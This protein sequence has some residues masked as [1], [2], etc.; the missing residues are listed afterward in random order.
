MSLSP[1]AKSHRDAVRAAFEK[2]VAD[3]L[4]EVGQSAYADQNHRALAAHVALRL[5]ERGW[6]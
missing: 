6:I 4:S 5:S 1:E 3:A 2:D